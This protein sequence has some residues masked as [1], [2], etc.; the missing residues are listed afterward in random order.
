MNTVKVDKTEATLRFSRDEVM[1][2]NNALN[3]VS[4]GVA[5]SDAE[6]ETR[7]GADRAE[8][9]RLLDR[10]HSILDAMQASKE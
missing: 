2:L 3:E 6:F 4:N 9:R 5:I 8:A 1:L 7:L 10:I